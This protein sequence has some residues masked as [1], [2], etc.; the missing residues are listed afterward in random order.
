MTDKKYLE[1][2]GQQIAKIRK[3]K[4]FTQVE[5]ADK[6][7][8]NRSALAKIEIG[9]VNPQIITLKRI[10]DGLEISVS[11]LVDF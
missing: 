6:L 1:K 5:F 7:D 9:R 11:E 2:L 3:E 8:M 10:A 4:G